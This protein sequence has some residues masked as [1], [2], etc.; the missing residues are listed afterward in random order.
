MVSE[1]NLDYSYRVNEVTEVTVRAYADE[2]ENDIGIQISDCLTSYYSNGFLYLHLSLK[3]IMSFCRLR[4]DY[5]LQD[6]RSN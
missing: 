2:S 1:I 6:W 5:F 3:R 4:G